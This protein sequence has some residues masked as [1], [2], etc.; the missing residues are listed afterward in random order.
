MGARMVGSKHEEI[1]KGLSLP[2]VTI[3][4]SILEKLIWIQRGSQKA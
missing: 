2:V 1:F 3:E 4:D